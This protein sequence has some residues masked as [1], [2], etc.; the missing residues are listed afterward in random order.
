MC[1]APGTR[2]VA[3]L[4]RLSVAASD[5]CVKQIERPGPLEGRRDRPE[6]DGRALLLERAAAGLAHEGKNP[7]HTM[8]LHLHLL[9]DKLQKAL[10]RESGLDRHAQALRDGIGKV[11]ALLRAFADL[12]APGQVE[13]DL[14]T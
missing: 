6:V 10:P 14:G 2:G 5:A 12:A 13:P 11:D 7:L 9:A 4:A 1:R 3:R 8:A